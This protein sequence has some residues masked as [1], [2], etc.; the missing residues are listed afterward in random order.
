[1]SALTDLAT[2][3]SNLSDSIGVELA[4]LAEARSKPAADPGVDAAIEASVEKLNALNDALKASVAPA[5]P[6]VEAPPAG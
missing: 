1:M 4:A 6:V 2:A 3:V 5:V